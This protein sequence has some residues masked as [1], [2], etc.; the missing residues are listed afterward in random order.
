MVTS[1]SL[2]RCAS[3]SRNYSGQRVSHPQ[4]RQSHMGRQC[5]N[6]SAS[7]RFRAC[8]LDTWARYSFENMLDPGVGRKRQAR[9]TP[10]LRSFPK[11]QA[12]KKHPKSIC[13]LLLCKFW[14]LA[15]LL[16]LYFTLSVIQRWVDRIFELESSFEA[17]E[18]VF[19]HNLCQ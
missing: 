13:R 3:I 4:F 14:F 2:F 6:A 16:A 7:S 12:D 11:L 10:C 8:F 19:V 9:T 15:T 5:H 17:C 18:L 1:S